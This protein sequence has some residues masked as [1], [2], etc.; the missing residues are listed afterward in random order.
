EEKGCANN[1]ANFNIVDSVGGG[2]ISFGLI[3]KPKY[4]FYFPIK[5]VS[6]SEKAYELNYQGSCIFPVWKVNF[7]TKNEFK[8]KVKLGFKFL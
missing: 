1:I 4:L 6:Q 7:N 8:F 2:K 5:T 3:D